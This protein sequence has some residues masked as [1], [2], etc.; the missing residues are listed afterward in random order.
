MSRGFA[1]A[2]LFVAVA[3]LCAAP[4]GAAIT[5]S[6]ITSPTSPSF[7]LYDADAP[8][9]IAASG[10][11]TGG[12]PMT[13]LV[14][15]R[16]YYNSGGVLT[17]KPVAVNVPLDAGGGFAV[18][19]GD[20]HGIE[21]R[22]CRLRAIPA[23][24]SPADLTPFAGPVIATGH[25]DTSRVTSGPNTG[26]FYNFYTLGQ[27]L[28]AAD[29]FLSIGS[30]GLCAG[31]LY[32]SNFDNTTFTFW[33]NDYYYL[34]NNSGSATRSTVQVD[35]ADA[36][37]PRAAQQINQAATGFP[38]ITEYTK[39]VS[40]SNGNL[41]VTDV[42]QLAKC[43][44]A[45]YPPDATSCA[46]FIDTG[47][48]VHRTI[49]QEDDGHIVYITDVWASSDGT[50][51]TLD[52]QPVNEQRFW[53][54]TGDSANVAYKFPGEGSFSTHAVGD[55]VNFPSTAPGA[56]YINYSGAADGDPAHGQG[57][58][59]FDQ[60]SSP[61]HF[62]RINTSNSEFHPQ[63]SATIPAHGCYTN[64]FAYV[65]AF[66]SAEVNTEAATAL[67]RFATPSSIPCPAKPADQVTPPAQTPTPPAHRKNCKKK[68]HKRATAAKKCKKKRRR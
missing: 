47:V 48:T 57:A 38:Q 45:T 27:Q 67:S 32:D 4:A 25:S 64:R 6:A 13:D 46:S 22:V 1:A 61:A 66:T 26:A 35:G 39:S 34:A 31:Y 23:G 42:E 12:N 52:L 18:T 21:A 56:I 14:N 10:T 7:Q 50:A 9:T 53:K 43:P 54:S 51:H 19:N 17:S 2:S 62:D 29:D 49:S 15:L 28:T 68:K 40:P 59:V 3:L 41:T 65:Q 60:P 30:C 63:Q 8:N 16:C 11:T 5:G 33:A 55:S 37:F 44:S 58:I 36:Y 24:S 20:L